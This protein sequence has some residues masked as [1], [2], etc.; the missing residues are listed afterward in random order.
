MKIRSA[1]L[2]SLVVTLA[3]TAV[4]GMFVSGR[5]FALFLL[6]P[7]GFLF[8]RKSQPPQTPGGPKPI[9]PK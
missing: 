9:V 6:L 4:L 3:V 1:I 7:L 8:R 2:I 5:I